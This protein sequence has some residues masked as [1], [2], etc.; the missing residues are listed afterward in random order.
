MT[1]PPRDDKDQQMAYLLSDSIYLTL[2][3]SG[4]RLE[5]TGSRERSAQECVGRWIEVEGSDVVAIRN[6][7]VDHRSFSLHSVI[8][9]SDVFRVVCEYQAICR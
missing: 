2:W 7:G 8:K 9:H 5:R 6:D 1:S 4:D 3:N